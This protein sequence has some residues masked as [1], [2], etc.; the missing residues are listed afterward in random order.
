MSVVTEQVKLQSLWQR[1]LLASRSRLEAIES[2][3]KPLDDRF[4][5]ILVKE[6][7]QALKSRQFLITFGLILLFS[8][9]WSLIGTFMQMPMVY[10]NPSAPTLLWGYYLLLA[11][12]MLFV[13]PLAAFRSLAVEVDDGTLEL[14]QVST[15]SPTDIVL[16]K[17][18]SALL[19]M[20][21]YF[22]ALVPCVSYAYT[23]RGID[24]NS[25]L[26]LLI[27]VLLTAIFLTVFGLFMA[28]LPKGRSG[29]L[30]ALI[31]VVAVL[32]AAE[33]IIGAQAAALLTQNAVLS[34]WAQLFLSFSGLAIV[35]CF[36]W[37]LLTAAA[38][39]L[40]PV[41]ANRSTK[42][43]IALLVT[44]FVII[45]LLSYGVLELSKDLRQQ[46]TMTAFDL[47]WLDAVPMVGI[48]VAGSWM[49]IGAMMAV[50]S[51]TLTPRVRRDF[52]RSFVGRAMATFFM[53][54]SATGVAFALLAAAIGL[55]FAGVAFYHVEQ[56]FSRLGSRYEIFNRFLFAL[57]G[58]MCIGLLLIRAS[59]D[60]IRGVADVR[61]RFGLALLII[62]ALLTSLIPY[63]LYM[64]AADYPSS[65]TYNYSQIINWAWTLKMISDGDAYL[66]YFVFAA[67]MLAFGVHLISMRQIV[68]P[69]Y[70][71][72]PTRVLEERDRL[73][74]ADQSV[75]DPLAP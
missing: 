19:Q 50:E 18:C 57:F 54:G 52:P 30:F 29:Q 71:P 22:V 60:L 34:P 28:T 55:V 44:Q 9:G 13:V 41:C 2:R 21:L 31:G 74:W 69:Q 47:Q 36:S 17:L 26:V 48:G 6:T 68:L 39:E 1:S 25:L 67:G 51:P 23:L 45:G 59:G 58:Y 38:A 37:V 61:P 70:I 62:V 73:R 49:F 24:W 10:Y 8:F 20:M 12:P 32:L 46:N 14:L 66:H 40:A 16:G 56:I 64:I 3:L 5:P 43:R 53:P 42:L 4:N 65:P 11:V 63:S 75:A 33:V 35:L 7:R 15:L 72:T 27:L